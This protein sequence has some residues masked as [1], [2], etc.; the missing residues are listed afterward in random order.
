MAL[1]GERNETPRSSQEDH[2]QRTRVRIED[3]YSLYAVRN[4]VLGRAELLG[5]SLRDRDELDIIVRELVTNVLAHGGARGYV[6]ISHDLDDNQLII[7]LDVVDQGPGFDDFQRALGDGFSTTGSLG[8]GL[9]SVRRLAERVKLISSGP[10]G[11]HLRVSKRFSSTPLKPDR[12][13]FSLYSK[14]HPGESESGDQGTVVR[15]R[16]GTLLVLADG[17]G[18][19]SSAALASRTV[20]EVVHANH[21]LMLDELIGIIH[22]RLKKTRG[23]AVS[24]ARLVPNSETVEWLGVGNVMG[25]RFRT[26]KMD[27]VDQQVFANFNGTLGVHLGNFKTLRYPWYPGDWLM[28]STDGLVRNWTDALKDISSCT[29]HRLGRRL[30][31]YAARPKDDCSVLV[32]KSLV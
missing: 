6:E 24:L 13:T 12:W 3:E 18:H 27:Q 2:L 20:L 29:P 7:N 5:I 19:G 10:Q 25:R 31:D 26:S 32:G 23:A 17:L 9:P 22:E 4:T 8:G 11:S 28:L 14:P 30:V 16:E 21:R 15:N 1:E